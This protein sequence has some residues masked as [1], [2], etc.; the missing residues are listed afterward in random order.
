MGR[1]NVFMIGKLQSADSIG[2]NT[3]C[4]RIRAEFTRFSISNILPHS[5]S[6][7]ALMQKRCIYVSVSIYFPATVSPNL[8]PSDTAL[9]RYQV[10]G[11]IPSS[12]QPQIRMPPIESFFNFILLPHPLFL[13]LDPVALSIDSPFFVISLSL[14]HTQILLRLWREERWSIWASVWLGLADPNCTYAAPLRRLGPTH[15]DTSNFQRPTCVCLKSYREEETKNF[16]KFQSLRWIFC[17][18]LFFVFLFGL[19]Y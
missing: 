3:I 10:K 12:L 13:L 14:S 18:F 6:I 11:Y 16:P 9:K 1:D 19:N 17:F 7:F 5:P 4:K 15:A 8:I 2:F